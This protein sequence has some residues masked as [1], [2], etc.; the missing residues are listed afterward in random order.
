[1]NTI[2]ND[3]AHLGPHE[4]LQL[5][6]DLWDSIGQEVVPIMTDELHHELLRRVAWCN[7]HPD[8]LVTVEQLAG[9]LGVSL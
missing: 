6:E 4:K 9:K 8:Q 2:L 7:V 5:V 3:L 1:M